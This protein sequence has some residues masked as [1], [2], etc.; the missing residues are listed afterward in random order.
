MNNG[1]PISNNTLYKLFTE[2][3]ILL[4]LLSVLISCELQYTQT[5]LQ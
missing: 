5:E 1:F 3:L 4:L 2:L